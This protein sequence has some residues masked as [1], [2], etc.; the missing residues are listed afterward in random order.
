[1]IFPCFRYLSESGQIT[2][3]YSKIFKLI[4]KVRCPSWNNENGSISCQNDLLAVLT[5]LTIT[6]F[7]NWNFEEWIS[8][9][10]LSW[11]HNS[12]KAIIVIKDYLATKVK[13]TT[14]AYNH[15]TFAIGVIVLA[16]VGAVGDFG[17]HLLD[18]ETCKDSEDYSFQLDNGKTRNCSWFDKNLNK[19]SIRVDNY[20][21][22]RIQSNTN[23]PNHAIF[24]V[25]PVRIIMTITSNL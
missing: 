24:V 7:T 22:A 10:F 21:C 20:Y 6:N 15:A 18:S 17:K 23:A 8:F 12:A 14:S 1:M 9:S 19:K 25:S 4:S 13:N 2:G 11:T 3:D 16:V 5:V